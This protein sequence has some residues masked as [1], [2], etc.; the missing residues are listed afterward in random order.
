MIEAMFVVARREWQLAQSRRGEL[1]QPLLMYLII[2]TLF[3]LGLEP[4]SPQL[5][6]LAPDI[7]WLSALLS[8]L[9]GLERLFRDDLDDGTLEQVLVSPLPVTLVVGLKLLV[10]WSLTIL[11]LVL[12]SPFVSWL[13]G[14]KGEPAL[15]LAASL[16]LGTPVLVLFGGF[17]SALTV[18]LPRAGLIL[19]LLVLP[20]ICPV[21]IFGAGA[22][23]AAI[24]GI[25]AGAPLYFLAAI[26]VFS[27]TL[28]PLA[29]AAALRNALD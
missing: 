11:P 24:H 28:I 13:L 27:L 22:V 5:Q 21:M 18:G 7:V 4:N 14:L 17:A 12:A 1:I 25:S 3:A 16:L 8:G 15:V 26:L 2:V 6:V 9:L 20:M 23:R 19:P 29:A 10:H